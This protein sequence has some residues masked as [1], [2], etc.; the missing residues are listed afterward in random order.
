MPALRQLYVLRHAKSS[1]EDPGLDDHDRPLAPRGRRAVD[2][3]AGHIRRAGIEPSLVL[4]ST[5]RRTRETLA[6]VAP[7][8]VQSIEPELYG[9]SAGEILERLRRVPEPT[10][11]VMV[12]GHNPAMQ[13]LIL[14][15]AAAVPDDLDDG[16]LADVRR[17]F[18]TGGLATL[19]FAVPWSELSPG[20]A[21]LT[22][23][24]RP[25]H[26]NGSAFLPRSPSN[27]R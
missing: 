27:S 8:G 16:D 26:L 19:T 3:L 6:G 25:K 18:P 9:A 4:C 20:A 1:W 10:R 5:S 21:Q 14:R 22:A 17:K 24:V 15:L 7:S 2:L 13:I 12:I 23:L 11:S